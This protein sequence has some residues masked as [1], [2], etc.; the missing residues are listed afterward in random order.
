MQYSILLPLAL[1][2]VLIGCA[3]ETEQKTERGYAYERHTDLPGPTPQAGEYAYFHIVMRADDS[4]LN[5]SYNMSEIPRLRIPEEGQNSDQAAPIVD[6]LKLMSVGDSLTLDFPLDSLPQ[7]PPA[8]ANFELL[9]YDL[10]LLEIKTDEQFKEEMQAKMQERE[11][12]MKVTQARLPEVEARVQQ[13]TSDYTA[14]KLTDIQTAPS[15]LKYIIYDEGEG[16]KAQNGDQVSVHY[17]GA[18]LDGKAFDNSFAKGN[19]YTF[20]L[21]QGRVI[22]GWDLGILLLAKGGSASLFI[23]ADL[24]Y[25]ESGY[26]DIPGGAELYFYV[27]LAEV[28]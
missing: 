21:G 23:P 19:P 13:V 15:G 20:T 2:L 8:F 27:E 22:R 25:G 24:A 16:S 6:G 12:A 4:I 9:K 10:K 26:Q 5:T 18:F 3:A 1:A 11:E 17:Y 14:G 28:N 7:V